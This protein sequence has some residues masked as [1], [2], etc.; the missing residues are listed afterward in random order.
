MAIKLPDGLDVKEASHIIS[1]ARKVKK[2]LDKKADAYLEGKYDPKKAARKN[3]LRGATTLLVAV[4]LLTGMAFTDPADIAEDKDAAS[5]RSA[6]IV[7]DVDEFANTTIDDDAEDEDEDKSSKMGIVARFRQAVLSLNAPLRILIITP[8]WAIGT[9]LMTV[10]SFLWNIIFATP[11]GAFIASL[12]M[13]MLV[14]LG[15]FT[16]T[17]HMLFPDVPLRDLLCRRNIIVLAITALLLSCIDA[18]A[19]I[20]WHQYPLAAALLK[21][22]F[23]GT[24]IGILSVK[25]KN[26]FRGIQSSLSLK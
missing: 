10:I 6:P 25:T 4:S 3:V 20:Y 14:L 8:L 16:A 23:G 24:I 17:A 21:L 11:L 9:A 26:L 22:I 5:Y 7:M 18:I 13:G 19:P 2:V 1:T 12:A 15:L